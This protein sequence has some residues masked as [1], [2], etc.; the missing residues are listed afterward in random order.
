M[1]ELEGFMSTRDPMLAD[2]ILELYKSDPMMFRTELSDFPPEFVDKL[3]LICSEKHQLYGASGALN[4]D[5]LREGMQRVIKVTKI[6]NFGAFA[7]LVGVS[8]RTDGLIHISEMGRQNLKAGDEVNATI[9]KISGSRVNLSMNSDIAKL[10]NLSNDR[11]VGSLTSQGNEVTDLEYQ[12]EDNDENIDIECVNSTPK[13]LSNEILTS[14]SVENHDVKKYVVDETTV[15]EPLEEADAEGRHSGAWP[16]AKPRSIID[17]N[18]PVMGFKSQVISAVRHNPV[19]VIVGDTGSG[20]STKI[21][22]FLLEQ[23]YRIACTQPRRVAAISLAKR[24]AMERKTK[25]GDVVGYAVRFEEKSSSNTKIKFVTDGLLQREAIS[26]PLFSKYSVL[27]L[28]EAHERTVATDILFTLLKKA[29]ARR[30]DLRV[31]VASATLDAGKFSAF[32]RNAPVLQ[33]PGRKYPVDIKYSLNPEMDYLSAMLKAITTIHMEEAPGD[34]LVFLTGKEEI[35]AAANALEHRLK[36]YPKAPTLLIRMIY[37]VMPI[38]KQAKIFDVAPVGGRKVVL[39]TN[40]AETSLTIEGIRYVVDPGFAKT[41]S[42]SASHG[43][44]SLQLNR[45][46]RAQADQRAGRAGRTGPGKCLRLYTKETYEREMAAHQAPEIQRYNLANV[47]LL[48]KAMGI[49]DV[50]DFEFMDPPARTS[51][52]SSLQDLYNLGALDDEGDL[53]EQGMKMAQYPMDPV[54]AKTLIISSK[55]GCTAEVLTFAAMLE[56]SNT[57]WRTPTDKKERAE[58]RRAHTRLQDNRGDHLTFIKLYN[59][60]FAKKNRSKNWCVQNFIDERSMWRARDIRNQLSH[61]M[62]NQ[63]DTIASSVD[64]ELVLRVLT[65]GYF[66]NSARLV[67]SSYHKVTGAVNEQ[68]IVIHPQSVL[69]CRQPLPTYVIYHSIVL[70]SREFMHIV[71]GIKPSWLIDAAPTVFTVATDAAKRKNE[72][73]EHLQLR[74]KKRRTATGAE[75][76]KFGS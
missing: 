12:D 50:V 48:L 15:N 10:K 58:A 31:L 4:R 60:W 75:L 68:A 61:I 9:S 36:L 56:V 32:F 28:D 43:F 51:L 62:V 14:Q 39:A 67:G 5:Q 76:R 18:L 38:E 69:A 37:A 23:G 46:S 52:I 30:P 11:Q 49:R 8:P 21:P 57:V 35:E 2:Y 55:E 33:I 45:I 22:Q 66:Q 74:S 34:I 20:K 25:V 3:A 59:E 29:V 17:D 53:T 1:T 26:D 27:M 41:N 73:L 65:A 54:L 6:V 72:T 42:W 40:I 44:Y 47:V 70:T 16:V 13:F 71:S 64:P 63:G 7:T 19:V 24:V